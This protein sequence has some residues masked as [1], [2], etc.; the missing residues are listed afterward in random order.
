M[1]TSLFPLPRWEQLA[2]LKK[3]KGLQLA[4]SME[5]C[6]FLQECGPTQTQLRD[7]L[8]QLETLQPGSSKD[9][10]HA[11]Q[12]T[13]QKV[14]V[15]ESRIHYLQREATKYGQVQHG[16]G[17][18]GGSWAEG[19]PE[20]G[21]AVKKGTNWGGR[22]WQECAGRGAQVAVGMVSMRKCPHERKGHMFMLPLGHGGWGTHTWVQDLCLGTRSR[23]GL[24]VQWLCLPGWQSQALRTVSS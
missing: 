19:R 16:N 22:K 4:R 1:K 5:V 14:Q 6:G 24:A 21:D 18:L 13:L 3:E 23:A 2:A 9:D 12:L 8:L 15:L 7:V 17:A 10:H 11:L 20:Q